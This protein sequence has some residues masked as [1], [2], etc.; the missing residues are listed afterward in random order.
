[1]ALGLRF[2]FDRVLEISCRRFVCI[3][4]GTLVGGNYVEV[5]AR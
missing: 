1:M 2:Y 5:D 3:I 4:I